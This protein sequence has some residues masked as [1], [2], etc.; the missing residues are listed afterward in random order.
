MYIDT[1][2]ILSLA[3]LIRSRARNVALRN[4]SRAT[5]M[6]GLSNGDVFP[7]DTIVRFD[8]AAGEDPAALLDGA[9]ASTRAS[10]FWFYG[11]D[12]VARHAAAQLTLPITAAGAVFAR[13]MDAPA[14]RER[15]VLRPP[16]THDRMPGEIHA[17]HAAGF[18][19]PQTLVALLGSDVIGVALSE[20]LD[21]QWS[22][23]R[24]VVYP[25]Y[26]GRGNGAAI[27]AAVA[28]ELE[29]TGRLV[30]A[31]LEPAHARGRAALETAGFR[32]TD[33]YFLGRYAS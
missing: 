16:A 20:A 4:E 27:F 2:P 32:L 3:R 12:A 26:R 7:P 17:D 31:A 24:V 21:A 8:I 14:P 25:S 28:D 23:V 13:R 9:F 6:V 19:A 30:C 5:G 1:L 33:Y 22:E 18:V 15:I 29:G 11:G 10:A